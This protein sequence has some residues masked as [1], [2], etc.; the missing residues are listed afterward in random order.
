MGER[1][2]RRDAA[3]S[4][5][6]SLFTRILER[7]VPRT[8]DFHAL[9]DAQCDVVVRGADALLAYMKS[10]DPADA[11]R[12][13]ALEHEGDKL[14]RG[15]LDVLHRSF[16]TPLD[17]EDIFQAIVAIDD[18]LNYAKATVTEME[19]LHVPPDEHT[20]AMAEL[21]VVGARALQAGF[22]KLRNEPASAEADAE[23][24]HKSER[25]T[26]RVYRKA[27]TELFDAE[28]YLSTQTTPQ[29]ETAAE[30]KVLLEPQP[31]D[32]T[33][34]VQTAVGFV[35]EILKRREVYRHMSNAADRVAHAGDVLRDIVAKIA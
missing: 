19:A 22:K 14:K 33:K 21:M 28:H 12:V 18:V 15:N 25:N 3:A 27:L 31:H 20:R 24:A 13:R 29:R 16:S 30:M 5:G 32:D 7:I 35:I 6:S 8:P 34:G 9:L 1:D 17:R 23:A 11:E 26:E 10:H 2:N 4:D